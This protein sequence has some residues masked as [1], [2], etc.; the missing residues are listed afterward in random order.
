MVIELVSRSRTILLRRFLSYRISVKLRVNLWSV[1]RCLVRVLLLTIGFIHLIKRCMYFNI[2]VEILSLPALLLLSLSFFSL[3]HL[4]EQLVLVGLLFLLSFVEFILSY[5]LKHIRGLHVLN[6]FFLFGRIRLWGGD[7]RIVATFKIGVDQSLINGSIIFCI[8]FFETAVML[9]LAWE[10]DM[11]RN[12]PTFTVS[13]RW[14]TALSQCSES[15]LVVIVLETS[16]FLF[17]L[18]FVKP[19]FV[20]FLLYL[21]QEDCLVFNFS[22]LLFQNFRSSN[23]ELTTYI[24]YLWGRLL[25]LDLI[26]LLDLVLVIL[27]VADLD[28]LTLVLRLLLK[29]GI[30]LVNRWGA[31]DPGYRAWPTIGIPLL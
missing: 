15:I 26:L 22:L 12:D 27:L 21:S 6:F 30:V 29:H 19:L 11:L 7:Q 9:R 31:G 3:F 17:N 25:L 16:I 4:I 18:L 28:L 1:T 8:T 2:I 13:N 10:W 20:I 5:V 24:D 23:I 14:S